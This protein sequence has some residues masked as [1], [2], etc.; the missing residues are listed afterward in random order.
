MLKD[1]LLQSQLD[2]LGYCTLSLLNESEI[3]FLS[4]LYKETEKLCKVDKDF[5]TSIWSSDYEYR[6]IVDTGIKKVLVPPLQN[7]CEN[8]QPVFANFMVKKSG[9]D[10]SLLPHQDWSFVDETQFE[11][12]TVWVPLVSVT[13]ENGALQVVPGSHSRLRNYVRSR[14]SDADFDRHIATKKLVSVPLSAGS[15]I[16]LNSRLVHASPPNNSTQNRV[17]ASVVIASA[18]TKLYHWIKNKNEIVRLE[19]DESFFYRFSCFDDYESL[20]LYHK[21]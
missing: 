6:K 5:F 18:N 15:A 3:S 19:V 4:E 7:I 14:F 1:K 11:S 21:A 13:P 12:F 20:K 2:E 10:S 17:V 8:F 9:K 16:V